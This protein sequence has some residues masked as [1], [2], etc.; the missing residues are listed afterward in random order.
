[1]STKITIWNMALGFIGTRT[2]A[3]EEENT[4]EAVQCKLYWDSARRS[5]L[6]DFPWNFAQR[7]ALLAEVPLPIGYEQQF[8]HAYALP[9]DMLQA[10]KIF[11]ASPGSTQRDFVSK[12]QAFILVHDG[13]T[14]N[15]VLLCHEAQAILSYT[16]N[17]E[18]V[19]L[20]D[21]CFILLLARKLA[22]LIAVPLLKNNAGR[23]GEL[24]ELYQAALPS[25]MQADSNEGHIY[26]KP[27][28]WIIAR[29][30]YACQ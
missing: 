1:M 4:L 12:E 11:S 3:S 30:S 29:G 26:Q 5:A 16:A 9:Q 18:D 17:L 25:A 23:V 21:D 2:I 7:R 27:D 14:K 8:S 22:A 20:F 6:R 19:S 13:Q 15:Q 28:S 10:L 24:E